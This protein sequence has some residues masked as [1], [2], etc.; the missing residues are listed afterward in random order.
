MNVVFRVDAS[1]FIGSGHVMRCLSLADELKRRKIKARFVC[2][3]NVGHLINFI[4]NK[5]YKVHVL[6]FKKYFS[7]NAGDYKEYQNTDLI[8]DARQTIEALDN[9]KVDW[10]IVAH[11]AI[12]SK[13]ETELKKHVK[14]VLVIDDL[15]NREHDCD[16]LL[17]QNWFGIE[18]NSRYD[19]LIPR[20]CAPLLGPSFALLSKDYKIARKQNK[21]HNGK[22]NRILIFM[23]SVDSGGQTVKALMALCLEEL[24]YISIDIVIGNSNKDINKIINIASSRK[25]TV[26]H[27]SLPSLSKLML[28]ADLML[29]T[30]GSTT[31][32]RCCLGLPAI[33]VIAARNQSKFTKLLA[34]D[35]VQLLLG[36][37]KEINDQDW[38]LMIHK[39]I[40][41]KAMVKEMSILSSRIVDGMGV[42][43]VL[44]RLYGFSMP[45]NIRKAT[46]YD[47][48][49]LF[50][51]ANDPI[52]RKFSFNEK[53]IT[54]DEHH[55][56]F[57]CKIN[58]SDCLILIGIDSNN[59]PIGQV[60]I[61]SMGTKAII[62]ISIDSAARG[63]GFATILLKQSVKFWKSTGRNKPLIGDVFSLNKASQKVFKK[64]G[65]RK[66][67]N[68]NSNNVIRYILD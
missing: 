54:Y 2:R 8:I 64:S 9:I 32:E 39:L 67:D 7:E 52:V 45:I 35:G 25:K 56:W 61:D 65:F 24:K 6:P 36:N 43:R 30:G 11:Y 37:S 53:P 68:D 1:D 4:K 51:W 34:K 33:I 22:I 23:G 50:D 20:Y 27:K 55:E 15:A 40:K 13:W 42:N 44:L 10:L 5:G 49:I 47:E 63:H 48:K 12:N 38:F 31:W 60:R 21:A 14:S 16:I 57:N 59:I 46:D 28:K 62:D 58:D 18:A 3:N 41:D 26:I 19:Q 17:D 29:C 66:L